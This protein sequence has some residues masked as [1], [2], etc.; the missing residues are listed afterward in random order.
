MNSRSPYYKP[1]TIPIDDQYLSVFPS[2]SSRVAWE[3]LTSNKPGPDLEDYNDTPEPDP[4][5]GPPPTLVVDFEGMRIEDDVI[6]PH[7]TRPPVTPEV[8]IEVPVEVKVRK[9]KVKK[10]PIR[11]E[12]PVEEVPPEEP[13]P[14]PKPPKKCNCHIRII[15]CD[16]TLDYCLND[17]CN[18][19][20][21]DRC[22]IKPTKCSVSKPRIRHQAAA[23]EPCCG[24]PLLIC[25][26]CGCSYYADERGRKTKGPNQDYDKENDM[27]HFCG[28]TEDDKGDVLFTVNPKYKA[29]CTKKFPK[30]V[31]CSCP[32][33][34]RFRKYGD[35][36]AD[37]EC[38]LCEKRRSQCLNRQYYQWKYQN[39]RS[40]NSGC[41]DC[42]KMNGELLTG[43]KGFPGPVRTKN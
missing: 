11:I 8:P 5:P 19:C 12:S 37:C 7:E 6:E 3:H 9:K 35:H 27:I 42:T 30:K 24:N 13:P 15:N 18:S 2:N 40:R 26:D 29:L 41:S 20:N 16:E 34:R 33:C 25:K 1:L 39:H 17:C 4:L 28:Y 23:V 10:A 21:Y 22:N 43:N 31:P 36:Y 14:P 32:Y 38:Q